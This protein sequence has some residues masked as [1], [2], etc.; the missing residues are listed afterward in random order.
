VR[1]II[2]DVRGK[3]LGAVSTVSVLVSAFCHEAEQA[4]TL[5]ELADRL[6]DVLTRRGTTD[7]FEDF[8]TAVLLQIPPD[9]KTAEVLNRG[10]PPPYL[11]DERAVAP[12]EPTTH[13]LPL[14][15]RLP[16]AGASGQVA[17]DVFPLH[18]GASLLLVTDG[19]TEARDDSGE[20]YDPRIRLTPGTYTSPQR[21]VNALVHDV[22][23]WTGSQGQD[24]MA[25]LV[26]TRPPGP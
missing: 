8:T 6:D 1:A 14:G 9:G 7:A 19:A 22:Y 26:L 21:L 16:G 24:D 15:L 25:V 2:G 10:H 23:R 5:A 20:F 3:G 12:L 11:V 18:P 17:A 4:P 13:E